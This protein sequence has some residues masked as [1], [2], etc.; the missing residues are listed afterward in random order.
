MRHLQPGPPK[1]ALDIEALI[2]LTTVQNSLVAANLLG[3]EIERLDKF[4]A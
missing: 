4:Q 3:D 2:R 1:P